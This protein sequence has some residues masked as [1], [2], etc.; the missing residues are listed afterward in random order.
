[1]QI[2][3]HKCKHDYL[4]ARFFQFYYLPTKLEML[5]NHSVQFNLIF[6]KYFVDAQNSWEML[7][8][9]IK[10]LYNISGE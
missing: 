9:S 2:Y 5:F 7:I 6:L 3:A 1:M 8:A 4:I 10:Y